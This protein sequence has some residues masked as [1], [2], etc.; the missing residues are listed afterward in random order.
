MQQFAKRWSFAPRPPCLRRLGAKLQV[1]HI[2]I[3]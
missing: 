2:S 3:R 1:T